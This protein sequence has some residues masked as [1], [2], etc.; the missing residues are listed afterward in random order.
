MNK[1]LL[2][3]LTEKDFIEYVRQIRKTKF[4]NFAPLGISSDT[5]IIFENENKPLRKE[6]ISEEKYNNLPDVDD[7]W[8]DK[9][10]YNEPVSRSSQLS[11][12]KHNNMC[13]LLITDYHGNF[14][15]YL[16]LNLALGDEVIGKFYYEVFQNLKPLMFNVVTEAEEE[17]N[18]A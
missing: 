3:N 16:Q 6:L 15:S 7:N 8:V 18:N 11:F 13:E 14:L 1:E 17:K 12:R 4:T 5:L 2:D 10:Y 9:R